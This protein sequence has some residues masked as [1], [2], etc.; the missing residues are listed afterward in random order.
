[1]ENTGNKR[2]LREKMFMGEKKLLG[3]K[4]PIREKREMGGKD[5][6]MER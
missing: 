5:G 2:W 6:W 4:I 1:M 3:E